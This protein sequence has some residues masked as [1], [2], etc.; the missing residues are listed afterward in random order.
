MATSEILNEKMC[1]F[2]VG[3]VLAFFFHC[4]SSKRFWPYL[5]RD[6]NERAVSKTLSVGELTL[7]S[8][9]GDCSSASET[10]HAYT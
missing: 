6:E 4:F 5:V 10:R 8:Q 9:Q 1:L 3:G 2:H 7:E